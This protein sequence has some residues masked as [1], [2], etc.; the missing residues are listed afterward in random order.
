MRTPPRSSLRSNHV[1]WIA[2]FH[3][4]KVAPVIRAGCSGDFPTPELDLAEAATAATAEG[5]SGDKRSERVSDQAL[6]ASS[7]F[8]FARIYQPNSRMASSARTPPVM[9]IGT[10][11]AFTAISALEIMI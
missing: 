9:V 8:G 2:R 3:F 5:N 1:S 7:R 10:N 6:I 4:L 11:G